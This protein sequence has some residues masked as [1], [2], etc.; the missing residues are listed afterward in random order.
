[1]R[2]GRRQLFCDSG[3]TFGWPPHEP[4]IDT[5]NL[6]LGHSLEAKPLVQLHIAR[7]TGFQITPHTILIGFGNEVMQ[8]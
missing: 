1:M 3:R 5:Y 4:D 8:D 6:F 2:M 7:G